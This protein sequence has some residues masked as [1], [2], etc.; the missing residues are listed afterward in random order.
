MAEND[1][2]IAQPQIGVLTQYTK[3]FSFENP[4][5]PESLIPRETPPEIQIN[6]NVGHRPF[7]DTDHEVSI[8]IDAKAR[9]GGDILFSAELVYAG[10]FRIQNVPAEQMY[11]I[12]MIECPRLL[13]PFARQIIS[14]ATR[15]GGFPPLMIDPIDF[16]QLYQQHI[17]KLQAQLAQQQQGNA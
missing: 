12:I 7:S 13:F 1:E 8:T 2:A 5:A 3:D 10:L 15:S 17:M 9:H 16:V 14:E 11:P 4:K 6:V